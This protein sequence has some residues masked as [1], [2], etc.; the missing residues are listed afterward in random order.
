MHPILPEK[1]GSNRK[2]LQDCNGV[3]IIQEIMKAAQAGGGFN[4]FVFTK[5]DGVTEA[6]KI[7]YSETF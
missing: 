1:E 5:S 3:M 6:P 2:E 7:A 4:E